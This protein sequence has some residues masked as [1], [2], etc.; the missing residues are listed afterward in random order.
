MKNIRKG[1]SGDIRFYLETQGKHRGY[2]KRTET[3]GVDGGPIRIDLAGVSDDDL[4]KLTE[5][6]AA[7][8]VTTEKM[9]LADSSSILC[10]H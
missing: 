5:A 6:V 10:L 9:S 1:N 3:T 8:L 2:S 4:G 7:G